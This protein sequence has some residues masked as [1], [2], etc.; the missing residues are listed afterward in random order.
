MLVE[1]LLQRME[2][3]AVRQA[4]HRLDLVAVHLRREQQARAH[5]GA[6]DGDG[7]GAADAVLAAEVGAGQV[8]VVAQEV[9]QRLAHLDGLLV[10]A[11]VDGDADDALDHRGASVAARSAARP[12]ARRVSTKASW[13]R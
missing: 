3:L 8:E 11:A 12:S 5:G 1:R 10:N 4:L 7:A 13:R 9:G 2:R 6:V